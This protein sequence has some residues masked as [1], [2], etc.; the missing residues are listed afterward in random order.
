MKFPDGARFETGDDGA[1]ATLE[2]HLGQNHALAGIRRL[3]GRWWTALG[4]LAM[5]LALAAAFVVYGIP[6]LARGAAA[7][8]PHRV[9]AVFDRETIELLDGEYLAPS[10]LSPSRQAQLQS[11]FR[12]ASSWAGGPTPT[13]CFCAMESRKRRRCSRLAPTPLPF[14]MELWS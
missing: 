14:P 7:A 3:E 1:V 6:T 4:A 2:R 11:A 8:T 10:T 12:R 13:A 5:T 9:L